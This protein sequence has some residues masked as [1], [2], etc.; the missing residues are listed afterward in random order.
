[1]HTLRVENLGIRFQ[2]RKKKPGNPLHSLLS[3]PKFSEY[4]WAL[5][6][7]SFEAKEGETIGIIGRNGAGKTTLCS[8]IAGI[9]APDEGKID[10][11]G[12]VVPILSLGV[13]LN[14]HITGRENILLVGA[15]LGVPQK[16]LKQLTPEILDFAEI[17]DFADNLV[18]TYSSGMHSRLAFAIATC[19]QPDILLLDEVLSVGDAGFQ[20]KSRKRMKQFQEQARLVM[21]VSHSPQLMRDVCSRA[22][23]LG[24]GKLLA[25]GPVDQVMDAYEE[26]LGLDKNKLNQIT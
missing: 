12:K 14:P 13:G 26:A 9:L 19:V 11:N 10:A 8:T 7:V 24:Q 22:I 17:E 25:D 3:A 2:L 16:R 23:W 20:Q 4:F 21:I 1:M 6:N 5:R 15:L 18:K